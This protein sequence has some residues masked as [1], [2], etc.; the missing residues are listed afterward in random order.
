MV[1]RGA[2]PRWF[3]V[4]AACLATNIGEATLLSP[5]GPGMLLW[6]AIGL[7]VQVASMSQ[8]GTQHPSASGSNSP[9]DVGHVLR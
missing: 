3:A 1:W 4:Y 6:C 2:D 9:L 5:G 8:Q 7:C